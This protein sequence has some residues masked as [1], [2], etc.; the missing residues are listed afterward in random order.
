MDIR[1]LREL[2]WSEIHWLSQANRHVDLPGV[3]ARLGLPPPPAEDHGSKAQRMS[4]SFDA[5]PDA[6]LRQVAQRLL[7]SHPPPFTERRIR[8]EEALWADVG[9]RI[10]K[11]FRRELARS[12]EH[13]DLYQEAGRFLELLEWLW[14]LDDGWMSGL[15]GGGGGSLRAQIERHVFRN[16]GDWDPEHLFDVTVQVLPIPEGG[17]DGTIRS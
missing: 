2:L 8:L 3:C 4:A 15:L 9:P 6:Q 16:P 7:E 1:H 17:I 10:P 12:L 14:C 5:V 13:S 11:R